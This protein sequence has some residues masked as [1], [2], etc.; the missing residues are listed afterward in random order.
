MLNAIKMLGVDIALDDFGTG[1]SSLGYLS[2][3][4]FDTLK[5]DQSFIKN[6]FCSDNNCAIVETMITLARTI[7]ISVVAEGVEDEEVFNYL[8]ELGCDEVQGYYLG[9]PMPLPELLTEVPEHIAQNIEENAEIWAQNNKKL[10]E[11]KQQRIR[12]AG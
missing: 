6:L 1:Y 3:F 2:R 4:P 12:A 8:K 11:K 9:K 5:I 10:D 7:N